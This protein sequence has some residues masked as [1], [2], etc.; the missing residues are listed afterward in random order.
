MGERRGVR[1]ERRQRGARDPRAGAAATAPRRPCSPPVTFGGCTSGTSTRAGGGTGAGRRAGGRRRANV[2]QWLRGLLNRFVPTWSEATG[3]TASGPARTLG[4]AAPRR[5]RPP[6]GGPADELAGGA[7]TAGGD[8]DRAAAC[9]VWTC[10][11][12]KMPAPSAVAR[13]YQNQRQDDRRPRD[14]G[15]PSE[16][17]EAAAPGSLRQDLSPDSG[18]RL[19]AQGLCRPRCV[20]QDGGA[21]FE[22]VG[23]GRPDRA[24][25]SGS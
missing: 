23:V 12:H 10:L 25:R 6:H 16:V 2:A 17:E 20:R 21:R 19:R 3:G 24:H 11:R 7:S 18:H 5:S 9:T 14:N 4:R 1:I 22:R 8:A 13:A 15:K